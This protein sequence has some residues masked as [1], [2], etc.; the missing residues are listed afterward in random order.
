VRGGLGLGRLPVFGN[1]LARDL[2]YAQPRQP[3]Q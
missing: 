2:R 1:T 3:G